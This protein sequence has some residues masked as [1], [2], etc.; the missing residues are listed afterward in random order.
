MPTGLE[1]CFL[2]WRWTRLPSELPIA[3]AARPVSCTEF[4]TAAGNERPAPLRRKP[5]R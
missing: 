5:S 2:P 1:I 3:F 4:H